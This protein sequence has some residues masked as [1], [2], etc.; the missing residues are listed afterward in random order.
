MITLLLSCIHG[1]PAGPTPLEELALIDEVV[2]QKTEGSQLIYLQATVQAGSAYDPVG[3]EGIAWLTAQS[4]RQ[5]GAGEL[6]PDEVDALLYELAAD[7]DVVVD[8]DLVSFRGKALAE[9]AEVFVPLFTDMIT[10]P[11]FDEAAVERLRDQAVDS[12]TISMLES[13]EALGHTAFDVWINEGHPYGH[14]VQGRAGVLPLLD[15]DAVM[16]FHEATY[17]RSGT[18]LGLAGAV[19]ENEA[20]RFAADFAALSADR[21]PEA[22]PKPRQDVEGR[23]LLVIEKQTASMGVHFGHPIEVDRSHEDFPELFLA[24]VA[25][26]EHRQSHGRLYNAIRTDRGL[27]YGDYAY[28]EHYVQRG[29]SSAQE[30]G[31]VRLQ[32]QFSVWLRPLAADAGPWAVKMALSMTEDLVEQ[33]LSA[34][35]FEEIQAYLLM[36]SRIWAQDPGTRL[37]YAVEAEALDL[38]DMLVDLPPEIEALTVEEVNAALQRHIRPDDLRIVVVAGD[39]EAVVRALTEDSPTP[40]VY[41]EDR[42]PDPEQ[43]TIDEEVAAMSVGLSE[44]TVVPAEGIFR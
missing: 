44:F 14:P 41:S 13:D 11:A 19:T 4:M 3:Q 25:F 9:D 24:M 42:Q 36:K 23:H 35:E 32:P 16:A 7:I 1:P 2:L 15:R 28:I 8:K 27:N 39:G 18:T 6:A 33:G 40:L 20:V 10:R 31:T 12:L 22:G 29:W 21:A 43:A 26:G 37:A 17:V 34:E 30:Q 5:G 38:P